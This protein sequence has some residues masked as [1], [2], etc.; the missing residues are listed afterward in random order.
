L[1]AV[2][3]FDPD[4]ALLDLG[5]PKLSGYDV[6]RRL[7][8]TPRAKRLV[9]VALTGWGQ[10]SDRHRSREAGFDAHL[11]KPVDPDQLRATLLALAQ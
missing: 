8:D 1:V 2:D 11:V 7:R 9:I 6:C 3:A 10:E 5:L 4:V